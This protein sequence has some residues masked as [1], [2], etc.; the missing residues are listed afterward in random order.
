MFKDFAP[1]AASEYGHAPGHD[2]TVP[3]ALPDL[4][5]DSVCTSRI[6]VKI[7][8]DGAPSG[9]YFLV[10]DDLLHLRTPLG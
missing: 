7:C 10:T 5:R 1:L 6:V 9:A 3:V 2:V 8:E 4:C